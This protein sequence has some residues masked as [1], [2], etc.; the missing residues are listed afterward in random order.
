MESP[1]RTPPALSPAESPVTLTLIERRATFWLFTSGSLA[2][3]AAWISESWLNVMA[4]TDR[5]AYPAMASRPTGKR[6]C[7]R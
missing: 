4:A 2:F 3:C 5:I 6:C 7:G 1:S